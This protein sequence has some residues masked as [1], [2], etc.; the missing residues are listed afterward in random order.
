MIIGV[1][2]YSGS[3]KDTV[4]AII[5]YLN[6]K[7]VRN[8]PIEEVCK[9]YD[10]HQEWL[11]ED[12]G[13]EIKKFAGKLKDI[14]S[15]LTG[16]DIEDFEDQ[17]FKK[18]NLGSEWWTTCDEGY[19]P[20]TVRDFLQKL[21]TDALRD[22]LHPNVWVNALMVDYKYDTDINTFRYAKEYTADRTPTKEERF[23][24]A[25]QLFEYL[26]EVKR[27]NWIITDVR[28]ENEAK[29]IKEK[30]GII[31]RVE[32]PGVKP[33]NSHP[34]ETSLDSWN[35]DYKIQNLDDIFAL[36]QTVEQI[37]KHAKLL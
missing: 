14:A 18:T 1:S 13:W 15:H 27:P 34:S 20:M 36:K 19:Q 37:L 35:F 10:E 3:G 26:T 6:C 16:L 32:R 30:K 24:P 11:E 17:E 9:N 12:S 25:S 28:F 22:A 2:G 8:T 23:F 5:Q 31:L 29:A 21:G 4:G 7:N 33:V